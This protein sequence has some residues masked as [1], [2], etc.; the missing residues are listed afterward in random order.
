MFFGKPRKQYLEV[1]AQPTLQKM[2]YTFHLQF[3]SHKSF[4]FPPE[5]SGMSII[6]CL[7]QELPFPLEFPSFSERNSSQWPH[8][9]D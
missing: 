9:P 6:I 5:Y 4:F 3:K 2:N 1:L 8:S 7:L